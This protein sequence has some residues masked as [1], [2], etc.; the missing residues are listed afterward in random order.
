MLIT[1]VPLD[2]RG[3]YCAYL[4]ARL[5]VAGTSMPLLDAARE[6][7]RLA[8][9]AGLIVDEDP[10]RFRPVRGRDT[11]SPVRQTVRAYAEGHD[12]SRAGVEAAT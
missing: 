12:T 11:A 2:C 6:L 7:I 4:G 5:L 10:C 1:L 9:A 3:R 8:A